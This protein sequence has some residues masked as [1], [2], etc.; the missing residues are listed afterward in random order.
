MAKLTLSQFQQVFS[1]ASVRPEETEVAPLLIR[2]IQPGGSLSPMGAIEVYRTGHLARLTE[3]L[4]ETYEAVWWVT[5]DEYFFQLAKEFLLKQGSQ[6]YNLSNF[7]EF[8]PGFLLERQPFTDL[9]FLG[10]LAQFEWTFKEVFHSPTH[11]AL[12]PEDFQKH[13]LSGDLSF[14]FAPSVR[15][16]YSPYSVY[17]IWKIRGTD[18]SSLPEDMWNLPQWLLCHKHGQHVYVKCVN[19]QDYL[20]LQALMEGATIEEALVQTLETFPNL[21]PS[22]VS[23]L[24]R[25]I[26]T[27]GIAITLSSGREA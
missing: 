16:F 2:E 8:F 19:E 23:E 18:Q 5:G 21:H 12:S 20:L 9:P 22:K 10:D 17:E 4:G 24:F 3:A 1:E 6:S 15:L 26:H 11:T 27:T 7:G 25:T 13:P 14:S